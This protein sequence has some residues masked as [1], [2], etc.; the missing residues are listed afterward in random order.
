M[1]TGRWREYCIVPLKIIPQILDRRYARS[2]FQHKLIRNNLRASMHGLGKGSH[3]CHRIGLGPPFP[4]HHGIRCHESRLLF[5]STEGFYL[6]QALIRLWVKTTK[7]PGA[8]CEL[9]ARTTRAMS[10]ATAHTCADTGYRPIGRVAMRDFP[11]IGD[12]YGTSRPRHLTKLHS[13]PM[14]WKGEKK[15]KRKT[16]PRVRGI[17]H[18][19][20]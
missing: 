20:A 19:V 7:L 14:I 2:R 8:A 3:K 4:Q 9:N 17:Y 18:V 10:P 12:L 6:P 11:S 1:R 5:L 13:Q 16:Q 15:M